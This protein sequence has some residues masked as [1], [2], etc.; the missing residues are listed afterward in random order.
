MEPLLEFL[1]AWWWA[2]P[3]TVGLGAVSYVGLTTGRRRARRLALDAARHEEQLAARALVSAKADTRSAQAQVLSAQA[4][5]GAPAPGIPSVPDARRQLQQAKQAQRAA[6]LALKAA[7]SRVRAERVRLNGGT[8]ADLPLAQLVRE[9]DALNARWLEYETDVETAL[10]FPQMSDPHHPTT[11]AFLQA[12]RDA[13]WLRP[14][15]PT[16]RMS[17]GDFVAYRRAV[18]T[19][20]AAFTAAE[21]A[22]LRAT[23]AR[24]ATPPRTAA[25]ETFR[26]ASA[27]PPRPAA[28]AGTPPVESGSGTGG[29]APSARAAA[30]PAPPADA[31]GRGESGTRRDPLPQPVWP[32]PGRR[33]R[34]PAPR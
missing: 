3:T 5:R 26:P 33:P 4:Q 21:D 13:Q 32:V 34:P 8:S 24:A 25:R 16:A 28:A 30:A 11:A 10:A 22:A 19:M 9:H 14:A 2:A 23:S 1:A 17:P 18:R 15:A 27:V 31:D 20:E 12:Q 29:S 7:R 6:G